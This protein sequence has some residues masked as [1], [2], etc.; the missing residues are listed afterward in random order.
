M[1]F[2]L[3]H[4]FG[5][6]FVVLLFFFS[7]NQL[8]DFCVS[9]QLTHTHARNVQTPKQGKTEGERRFPFQNVQR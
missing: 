2:F 4:T 1:D 8:R 7:F 9:E 6:G 5:G 3:K